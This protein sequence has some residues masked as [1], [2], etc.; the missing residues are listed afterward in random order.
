MSVE[1]VVIMMKVLSSGSLIGNPQGLIVEP[2][3]LPSW[4]RMAKKIDDKFNFRVC[5]MR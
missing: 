5:S 2:T 3:L 4:S 1:E